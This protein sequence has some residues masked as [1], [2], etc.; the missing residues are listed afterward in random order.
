MPI[1]K[2]NPTQNP[3]CHNS[4]TS[5]P[6]APGTRRGNVT[7]DSV[8]Q[9]RGQRQKAAETNGLASTGRRFDG[10]CVG[11]RVRRRAGPATP[12]GS[13]AMASDPATC[14]G[15]ADPAAS[16][17]AGRRRG[18]RETT[19]ATTGDYAGRP[20]QAADVRRAAGRRGA[21]P[22]LRR[23]AAAFVRRPDCGTPAIALLPETPVGLPAP[24]TPARSCPGAWPFVDDRVDLGEHVVQRVPPLVL[25]LRL[26][27]IE[28]PDEGGTFGLRSPQ[29]TQPG[30]NHGGDTPKA[31]GSDRCFSEPRQL[32]GQVTW[33]MG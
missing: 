27:L 19:T 26:G 31:A 30:G 11:A 22:P 8:G 21:G 16:R 29:Q 4:T 10:P 17:G 14:A 23:P 20:T 24:E 5:G 28:G 2:S 32:R 33:S 3:S 6:L 12:G 25:G 1:L 13:P 15:R 18:H 9:G 7:R